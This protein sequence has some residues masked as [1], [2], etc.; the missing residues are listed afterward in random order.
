MEEKRTSAV[1]PDSTDG[2]PKICPHCYASFEMGHRENCPGGSFLIVG[3]DPWFSKNHQAERYGNPRR[4]QIY[5]RTPAESVISEAIAAVEGFGCDPRLTEAS[6]LL[7]RARDLVAD[8]VEGVNAPPVS[9]PPVT[10]EPREKQP[11]DQQVSW[12]EGKKIYDQ[13]WNDGIE[14]LNKRLRFVA[15]VQR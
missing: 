1:S 3:S 5:L 14:E 8:F 13:G 6:V 4:C 7:Q 10:A 2:W 9:L 11:A 15:Q 12:S